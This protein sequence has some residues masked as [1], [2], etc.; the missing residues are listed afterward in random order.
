MSGHSDHPI[1]KRT[2]LAPLD[3][4]ELLA[5]TDHLRAEGWRLV[6]ILGI[7]SADAV[8]LNYSFGLEHE[9]MVIRLVV[10]PGT[11][12]PSITPVFAGAYLY[13]NE[14]RDLFGVSIER[15]SIDWLGKVYDVKREKPFSKVS[16]K[17]PSSEEGKR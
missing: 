4:G 17:M 7:S 8:E 14:I 2:T 16:I 10:P 11:S 15:I 6:Q 12:V 3:V 9:M 13:E 1:R 5:W